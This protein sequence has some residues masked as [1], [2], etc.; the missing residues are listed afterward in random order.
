MTLKRTFW[1]AI[2]GIVLLLQALLIWQLWRIQALA[3]IRESRVLIIATLTLILTAVLCVGE[4]WLHRRLAQEIRLT[5]DQLRLAMKSGRAVA[6]NWDLKSGWDVLLGDLDTIFGIARDQ[7]AGDV[8]DF[9][10]YVHPEDQPAMW[11]AMADARESGREFRTSL[12]VVRNDGAIRWV[13]ARGRFQYAANGAPER[14]FGI[15]MDITERHEM[16]EQ[17]RESQDRMAGFSQRLLEAHELERARI[18]RE[19]HDDIGQR[20]AVMT[21]D[22]DGLMQL[23]PLSTAD[24]RVRIAT[25]SNRAID[26]A[27]DVQA[28]SHRLHSSKLD[29]LG[30]ALAAAAF[31]DE[32]SQHHGIAI[33]F[34]AGEIPDKLPNDVVLCL[35]RVLQE[36]VTNAVRHGHPRQVTVELRASDADMRLD[37]VDDGSGFDPVLAMKGPGLGLISMRERLGLVGGELRIESRPGAGTAIRARAPLRNPDAHDLP[38]AG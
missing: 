4:Q 12:R 27:K 11:A 23:L 38:Q 8:A 15:A 14:L 10:R 7:Q 17:L 3:P 18:A 28:I 9:V 20:M 31:C 21:M 36:A 5:G 35:F 6:W 1:M 25:M 26:L 30:I 34:S 37:I 33:Q 24:L 29:H 16:E 32:L 22:L 2:V 13:T 19:L